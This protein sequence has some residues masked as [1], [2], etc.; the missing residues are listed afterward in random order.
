MKLMMFH[1]VLFVTCRMCVM[2]QNRA[3]KIKYVTQSVKTS[4]KMYFW[5]DKHQSL[6]VAIYFTMFLILHGLR[7]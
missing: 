3:S 4:L 5:D 7:Q 2:F 6:I 1:D